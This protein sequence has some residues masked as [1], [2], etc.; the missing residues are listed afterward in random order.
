[1][2]IL[3]HVPDACGV[4]EAGRGALAGPV[5]CAAVIL[6]DGF[7][8]AGLDDSKKLTEAQRVAQAAR[9]KEGAIYAIA[10]VPHEIIDEINILQATFLG[11][12]MCL[13][14]MSQRP[15][16]VLID[17]N[18]IPR[19]HQPDH[20]VAM[21]CSGSEI[22]QHDSP[23]ETVVKGDGT[24]ACIA[25][26][27]ILA[28]TTR[29]Q[30]MRDHHPAHPLYGFDSHVGYAAPNHLDAIRTHGPSPIHRRSF[31]PVRT[32]LAQPCLF[33]A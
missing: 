15:G 8:C 26:A 21:I 12:Q 27:S 6:P 28:K 19:H 10:V 3:A 4:D 13:G 33:G 23:Q 32:M 17:G 18:Q 14:R 31:D 22:H 9:I 20:R 2:H 16:K 5:V 11:M 1:M 7:D 29:D 30:I 24:Y 25:A